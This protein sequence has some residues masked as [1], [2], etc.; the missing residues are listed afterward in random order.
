MNKFYLKKKNILFVLIFF[1][2]DPEPP[3]PSPQEQEKKSKFVK[4][5]IY[6]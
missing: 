2:T 3:P 6:N 5:Y 1:L 4:M